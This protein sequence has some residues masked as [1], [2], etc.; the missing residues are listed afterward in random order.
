[1]HRVFVAAVVCA[2][3]AW[4]SA[5]QPIRSGAR[6]V[7]VY[8]TVA[9]SQGRLLTDLTQ[10][11]FEIF[12]NGR[13]Q[14]I[15]VFESG[16]QPITVVMLLDRSGSMALNFKLVEAAAAQFVTSMLPADR[17]RI[18]SF[19]S[20]IQVDPRDFTS[21]QSELL[22]ILGTELQPAGPTPLWNAVNVGITA[23][24]R[25]EGRRVILVF[26]DGVDL[27][28]NSNSVSLRDVMERSQQEDVMVYAIGLASQVPLRGRGGVRGRATRGNRQMAV[29]Q[30]DP[31]LKRIAAQSG[32]GYFE[33]TSA[34]NLG[35]TFGRIADE[36]HKQYLIGYAPPALDG[37]T[38]RIEVMVKRIATVRAR[39]SYIAAR[40]R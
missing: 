10:D 28:M 5:Q 22:R 20:R 37:K 6:T 13:R 34:D 27:P 29:Q 38:H 25:Q 1:M 39:R 8:A 9:D 35:P 24:L 4:L 16:I 30:P 15:T 18:G 36:L 14:P 21:D 40:E 2:A 7:A 31:G 33:L 32:G 11:D 12:D 23:L 17:A 26:T 3:G 19:A